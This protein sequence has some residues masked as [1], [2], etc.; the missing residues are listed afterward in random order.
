[1]KTTCE[2]QAFN[3]FIIR[4]LTEVIIQFLSSKWLIIPMIVAGFVVSATMIC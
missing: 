2:I 4:I 1:M 3:I